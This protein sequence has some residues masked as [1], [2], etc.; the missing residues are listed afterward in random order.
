MKSGWSGGV[1]NQLTCRQTRQFFLSPDINV[2]KTILRLARSQLTKL[3]KLIT[4]H[5]NLAYHACIKN[6]PHHGPHAQSM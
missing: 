3:V 6:R 4:G 2:S 1:V 5:N